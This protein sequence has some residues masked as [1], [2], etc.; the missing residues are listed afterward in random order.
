[1]CFLQLNRFENEEQVEDLEYGVETVFIVY[2]HLL[3]QLP[4]PQV[5]QTCDGL[6]T[7]F[8][9]KVFLI[10]FFCLF[11]LVGLATQ[12]F[13][14]DLIISAIHDNFWTKLNKYLKSRE[15]LS[16]LIVSLG[17]LLW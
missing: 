16:M 14:I 10:S 2:L 13:Q 3:T 7:T 8:P 1:M 17:F 9:Y 12:F 5:L 6:L 15:I 11:L 4:M